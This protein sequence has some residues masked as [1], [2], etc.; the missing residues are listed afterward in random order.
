MVEHVVFEK[1]VE[2]HSE[3]LY[4]NH[5]S[6]DPVVGWNQFGAEA[7]AQYD[8]DGFIVVR[9]AI[10]ADLIQAVLK[11][12]NEMT[13][14]DDAD[15]STVSFEAPFRERIE[16]LLGTS[17][18]QADSD[19]INSVISAIPGR[20]RSSFVRKFMGFTRTHESLKKVSN[21]RPLRD[22]IEQICGEPTRM[23]QSMALIK[24]PNGREKPWHQDHAYFDLPID[25]KICGVWIALGDVTPENGAMFV[26]KGAHREGP[27]I[28][29][30]RRDWQICD[31]DMFGKKPTAIPMKAGDLMIFDAKI[32]HG[33]PINRTRHH[34]WALQFHYAPRSA[35]KVAEEQRLA[36]FGSEGKNVEC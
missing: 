32:P 31:T 29:F 19:Q 21:Y 34:R 36:I 24:P 25:T 35:E 27:V 16:E 4:S 20:E 22:A 28:H 23:F 26:L 18:E 6:F 30:R 2:Q 17:V 9:K 13:I 7:V 1:P 5:G 10:P 3:E 11:E 33:T 8:R 14:A 12:L 15:C